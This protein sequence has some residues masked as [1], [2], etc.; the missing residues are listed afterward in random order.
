MLRRMQDRRERREL[1]SRLFASRPVPPENLVADI[2]ARVEAPARRRPRLAAALALTGAIVIALAATGSF[3]YAASSLKTAVHA[4][5]QIGDAKTTRT[6]SSS[7]TSGGVQYIL[8]PTITSFSPTSGKVGTTVTIN[9]THFTG[10]TNVR[11]HG[12]AAT[13]T[14]NSDAKITTTVPSG[15]TT[16]KITVTNP[17][18]TAT[19]GTNFIVIRPPTISSF[20]PA[21]GKVGRVVTITGTHFTGVTKVRFHGVAATFT[22]NSDTKISTSVPSGATSGKITVT[23]IAGTATSLTN[24][25]VIRPPGITSFAPTQGK[26]GTSVTINGTHFIGT[27]RVRFNGVIATFTV[28]SDTK[29]TAAVPAAASTGKIAVVNEAGTA[30]SANNFIVIKTPSITSFSPT[31]GKAGNTV[32]INGTHFTG[33]TSVKFNGVAATFTVN[34][35]LKISATVP[36]LATTGKIVVTNPAGSATSGSDFTVIG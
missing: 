13:F 8:P 5:T 6:L 34:T 16:G 3:G 15:A 18:G 20:A 26:A 32:T 24:F 19:S 21:Q 29:I 31:S 12:V 2:H 9:G 4:I 10:T 14:V 28:N 1:E 17:A 22:V 25:I 7:P 33:T 35:D 11:F 23:N 27:T 30:T 36:G